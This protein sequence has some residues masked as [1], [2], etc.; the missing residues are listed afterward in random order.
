MQRWLAKVLA[1]GASFILPMLCTVLP[2]FLSSGRCVAEGHPRQRF[3][4]SRLM[5]L[6]GGIFFGTY[7]LHMGPDVRQ[8][9]DQALLGPNHITYPLTELLTGIGF[10]IVLFT[11]TLVMHCNRSRQSPISVEMKEIE[12]KLDEDG[13]KCVNGQQHASVTSCDVTRPADSHQHPE[14]GNG[15]VHGG[16]AGG[17][18]HEH[19]HNARSLALVL[20]LSLHRIFEGMSVGLQQSASG[21]GN[22]LL[23]VMCH[24]TVIAFSLG[25]QFVRSQL[26]IKRLYVTS[27]ICS[28]I[29]PIGVVIGIVMSENATGEYIISILEQRCR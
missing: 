1:A 27:L 17:H 13:N 12:V 19:I 18:S 6:G 26:P 14:V 25:L 21:V 7:L 10:F 20:A 3:L 28:I 8:L 22:L 29:M 24:E 4:L 5:C 16:H 23:A 2:H 11:E 15:H 9:L